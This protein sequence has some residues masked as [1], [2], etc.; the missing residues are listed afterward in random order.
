MIKRIAAV[1]GDR[2]P[3]EVAG[4]VAGAAGCRVPPGSLVVIGD[5]RTVSVDSREL[6][7]IP[8][9]RVLG[10]ALRR[11]TRVSAR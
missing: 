8:G 7:L 2:L 1:P 4:A 3:A 10:V 11:Y 9:D 5:N 6:G